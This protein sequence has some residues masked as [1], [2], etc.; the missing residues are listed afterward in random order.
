MNDER[1]EVGRIGAPFGVRGWV[2]VE[3]YTDPPE[4]LLQYLEWELGFAGVE[5]VRKRLLAGRVHGSGLVAHLE[6]I[7]SRA[8]AARL[9]GAAIAI[10]RTALPALGEREYYRADLLGFHVRNLEGADLGEVSHFVDAPAGAVMVTKGTGGEEH[11]VR[12]A[13]PHLH[14]VDLSAREIVVDWPAELE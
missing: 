8:E 2:H 12:A 13:P 14:R 5:R 11:W 6:G 9:T 3:P 10:E 7:G 1:I 4:R